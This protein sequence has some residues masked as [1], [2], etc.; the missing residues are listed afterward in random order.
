MANNSKAGKFAKTE[1]MWGYIMVAPTII[2]LIVLNL[3]PFIDTLKL[4]FTKTKPFGFYEFNGLTNYITMFTNADFWRANLNTIYFCL[5]TVPLGIFLALVVAVM[6]N[7]KIKG[8][9]AFRAIFFLPMVVAPA[10]VA[11]VWK[12][13]FNTEYGIINTLLGNNV[14]WITNPNVVMVTC[15]IM[16]IWSA[17]GYDAVL[18]LSGLQN[19]SKSYYEAA[20]LD[21][22]TKIQQF[23]HITLP[24]VSP[25]LFVVMI[26]RLMSS[27]KVYD[28]IYMMV[29]ES[30]PALTSAQSLM[31]LF[32]RESFVAGNKG[33]GSAVVI[34]TVLLIGIVTA[35]QF[36]GQKKWVN[37]EV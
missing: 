37:Y 2:G 18:L 29:E 21:G 12:W 27:L 31:F 7:T 16:A 8:R 22:A 13:M 34:W 6:L 19:I 26:M 17:I 28:L 25:T 4:S 9:T 10:A 24:M 33:Y 15:A 5:L 36:W 23:F 11:M 32:Y 1:G 35:F 20:S 14:N 30:N 3:Y